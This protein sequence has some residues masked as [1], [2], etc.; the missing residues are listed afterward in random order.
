VL[1]TTG[2]TPPE[3]DPQGV[4]FTC[5]RHACTD[6]PEPPHHTEP[7]PTTASH[8]NWPQ[9]PQ[10]T[11]HNTPNHDGLRRW[12]WDTAHS[13]T[14]PMAPDTPCHPTQLSP[15]HH[16]SAH[17]TSQDH[18]TQGRLQCLPTPMHQPGPP[19]ASADGAPCPFPCHAALM[20]QPAHNARQQ[21]CGHTPL[22][23]P[24]TTHAAHT[25]PVICWQCWR[26]GRTREF[27]RQGHLYQS[28]R[29]CCLVPPAP[30]RGRAI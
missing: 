21:Q 2:E 10:H 15:Q 24:A 6:P 4:S 30:A 27:G 1:Q 22:L 19:H 28:R 16:T 11:T 5:P 20:Q 17:C 8:C 3:G 14:A 18:S 7:Q 23:I 29:R 25:L 12:S 9:V 26:T 13:P